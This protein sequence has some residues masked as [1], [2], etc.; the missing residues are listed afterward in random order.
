MV[1]NVVRVHPRK[2][3]NPRIIT[4]ERNNKYTMS[5]TKGNEIVVTFVVSL[6]KSS[7]VPLALPT[8]V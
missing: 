2:T 5:L 8:S 1:Y 7:K 3:Y 4:I 6:L